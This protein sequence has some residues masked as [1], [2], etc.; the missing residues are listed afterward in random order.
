RRPPRRRARRARRRQHPPPRPRPAPRPR[1]RPRPVV[2]SSLR[3]RSAPAGPPLGKGRRPTRQSGLPESPDSGSLLVDAGALT[4][5]RR[6]PSGGVD[7]PKGRGLEERSFTCGAHG[8][9]SRIHRGRRPA[10]ADRA[11]LPAAAGGAARP[12]G[13]TR[14]TSG[15][16][17][18]PGAGRG[19]THGTL[20]VW[21][22]A[23]GG[24]GEAR[25]GPPPSL[26]RDGV[27]AGQAIGG[28]AGNEPA[29]V[30]TL[31]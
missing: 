26:V 29:T 27:G 17:R 8:Q 18:P 31:Y 10:S 20:G 7:P 19:G 16:G 21:R 13:R 14:G 28:I 1:P 5:G 9:G 30:A 12:D 3:G 24:R 11:R 15:W 25:R 2:R 22:A 23:W 4:G 6:S